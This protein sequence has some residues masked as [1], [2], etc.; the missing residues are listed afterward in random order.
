MARG[1]ARGQRDDLREDAAP[2][3]LGADPAAGLAV[4]DRGGHHHHRP[5]AGRGV[6]V[7][8]LEPGEFALGAGG[9]AQLPAGVEQQVLAAPVRCGHRRIAD[10]QVRLQIRPPVLAQGVTGADVGA[11]P[12]GQRGPQPGEVRGGRVQFL[13]VP[14][15]ARHRADRQQQRADAAGRVEDAR[16]LRHGPGEVP[17]GVHDPGG[18]DLVGAGPPGGVEQAVGERVYQLGRG[19]VRFELGRL[20]DEVRAAGPAAGALGEQPGDRREAAHEVVAVCAADQLPQLHLAGGFPALVLA[21]EPAVHV[22]E[23]EQR[24]VRG[25]AGRRGEVVVPAPPV[26]DRG[27]GHPGHPGDLGTGDQRLVG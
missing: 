10:H 27:P 8:V 2:D 14:G 15:G 9:D 23:L 5:A 4:G 20:P 1:D 19:D 3:E 24:A 18:G 11:R 21:G 22:G 6:G 26:G 12:A 17:Y 25:A 7:G 16:V 13:P